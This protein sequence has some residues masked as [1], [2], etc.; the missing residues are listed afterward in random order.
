MLRITDAIAK[1]ER[2]KA[3][4]TGESL[5]QVASQTLENMAAVERVTNMSIL[6]PLV[7]FDKQEIINKGRDICTYDISIQPDQD[8]CSLFVPKR[9]ATKA[10]NEQ[11]EKE[12]EALSVDELVTAALESAKTEHHLL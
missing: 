3:V 8:C 7:G 10:R 2:A 6:R 5:G 1:K 4:V 11:L 9:P 12:E